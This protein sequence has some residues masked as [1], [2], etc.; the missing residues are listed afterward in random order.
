M[1]NSNPATKHLRRDKQGKTLGRA[2]GRENEAG[3]LG[4]KNPRDRADTGA[5]PAQASAED[6]R[7]NCYVENSRKQF[8]N[9]KVKTIKNSI[10]KN[11]SI[12]SKISCFF[13]L[14]PLLMDMFLFLLVRS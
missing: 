10:P 14:L 13:L 1:P 6:T 4:A 2:R 7:R 3:G 9:R 5:P 8:K 11:T 12:D